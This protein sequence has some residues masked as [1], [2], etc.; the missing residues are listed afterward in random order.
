MLSRER[1]RERERERRK[2][3]IVGGVKGPNKIGQNKQM[4]PQQ[5]WENMMSSHNYRD[6]AYL[7]LSPH[8]AATG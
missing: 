1:E 5:L 8:T 3:N 7:F 4:D 2:M 6:P